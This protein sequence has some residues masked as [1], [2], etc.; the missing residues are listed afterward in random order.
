MD[1][2]LLFNFENKDKPLAERMRPL[3]LK[4]FVGQDEIAGKDP[5]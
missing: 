5:Y 2:N 4:D 1:N 3:S